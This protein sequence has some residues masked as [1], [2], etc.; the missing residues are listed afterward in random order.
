MFAVSDDDVAAIRA[1]FDAGGELA[2][3]V[4]IRRRFR[5]ITDDD[6]ARDW[7]RRMMAWSPVPVPPDGPPKKR[8]A[9][10]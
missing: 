2:A 9:R 5:G 7:A 8:R 4:E 10:A 3:A 6:V 1:A